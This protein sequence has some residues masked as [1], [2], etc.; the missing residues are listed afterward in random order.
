MNDDAIAMVLS[1]D[2]TDSLVTTARYFIN[3][4]VKYLYEKTPSGLQ[5]G[6]SLA[7][8]TSDGCLHH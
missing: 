6:I 2:H 8:A 3:I 1:K 5:M 7:C 4:S